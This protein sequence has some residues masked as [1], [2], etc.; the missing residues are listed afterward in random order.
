MADREEL[1]A[2]LGF[3]LSPP[4][5]PECRVPAGLRPVLT[6]VW[7]YLSGGDL[8]EPEPA[9]PTACPFGQRG[10]LRRSEELFRAAIPARVSGRRIIE[11]CI[12]IPAGAAR[13][14]VTALVIVADKDR[15]GTSRLV[16][17]DDHRS[18]AVSWHLTQGHD[19]IETLPLARADID[20]WVG[21]LG[22]SVQRATEGA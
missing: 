3:W 8:I 10:E 16:C 15:Y 2:A 20:A 17:K 14:Y 9:S 21:V 22:P 13:E 7:A 6:Q 5:V 12:V 11:V 1:I 19:G 18:G 4:D